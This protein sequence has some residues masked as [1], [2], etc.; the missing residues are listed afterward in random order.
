MQ[1]GV[2]VTDAEGRIVY[3]NAAD[4]ALHGWT[5]EELLGRHARVYAPPDAWR[6]P[7]TV[8]AARGATR[9]R[10]E[11]VNVRKDGSLFLAQLLSDVVFDA[12]GSPIGVVTTCEDVTERRRAEES[13]VASTRRLAEVVAAQRALA[14]SADDP[15]GLLDLAL[16]K[17]RELTGGD[18]ALLEVVEGP[19]L[20]TRAAVGTASPLRGRRVPFASSLAAAAVSARG[21]VASEDARTDPRADRATCRLAGARSLLAVPLVHRGGPV[22]ALQVLSGEPRAFSQDAIQ[23]LELL[24]AT[25]GAAVG[26]ALDDQTGSALLAERTERLRSSEER[27]GDV[28]RSSAAGMALLSLD[29]KVLEVNRAFADMLGLEAEPLAG[30][31]LLDLVHPDERSGEASALSRLSVGTA[32]TLQGE[33]RLAHRE[34][35]SVWVLRTLTRLSSSAAEAPSV[36]LQAQDVTEQKRAQASLLHDAFHD[37]LT[38]LPNRALFL[39]RLRTVMKRARRQRLRFAVLFID[40]DRFKLVNDSLGHVAGDQLLVAVARRLSGAIRGEDTVARLGGDEFT[41]LIDDVGGAEEALATARR[42]LEVLSAPFDLDGREVFATASVGVALGGDGPATA[43]ELLRDAD[44]A[45]YQAKGA[46]KACAALFDDSMRERAS[47]LLQLETGL[48][49]ALDRGELEVHYQPILDLASGRLASFEALVRWRHPSR[50]LLFPVDFLSVA[51]ETG[52]I[53]PIGEWVLAESCRSLAAWQRD[54]PQVPPL[55]ICVNV[56]PRQFSQPDLVEK[57][58]KVLGESGIAAGTLTLELTEATVVANPELTSILLRRLR[59]LGVKVSIDDFGTGYSSLSYLHWLPLDRLKIDRSFV[60]SVTLDPRNRE[61]LRTIA[62]LATNL[63]M[64]VVA[65]GVETP[66]QLAQLR[67]LPCEFGQGFLFSRATDAF[68]TTAYLR[69]RRSEP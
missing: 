43:D 55:G 50:G 66:E 16:A 5:R 67:Q 6:T 64:D 33:V 59:A 18:G 27:F 8:E 23:W 24:T 53:V 47:A 41:V 14:E 36:I 21:V 63:G 38:G 28:F 60:S 7:L 68:E 12:D 13:V 49:R 30:T 48:R 46:G 52:L 31:L 39:D 65:E 22:A 44:T 3:V 61:I 4:A 35:R 58:E 62:N 1:L 40:L 45:L 11:R 51:E 34:G 15:A 9:W 42:L 37:G 2:T 69:A 19:D 17:A 56:S 10:R 25:L 20:V 29:G 54:F 32:R 26:H 57:V